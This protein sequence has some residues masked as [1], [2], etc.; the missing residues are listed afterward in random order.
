MLALADK[1]DSFFLFFAPRRTYLIKIGAGG[2]GGGG[3]Q[4][5]FLMI[6]IDTLKRDLWSVHYSEARKYIRVPTATGFFFFLSLLSVSM[7]AVR[8]YLSSPPARNQFWPRQ[9]AVRGRSDVSGKQQRRKWVIKLE[10][11]RNVWRILMAAA[12]AR[13]II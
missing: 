11:S 12:R 7:L 6:C 3:G 2:L 4:Q 9:T 10:V 5:R 1:G 8:Q 13:R